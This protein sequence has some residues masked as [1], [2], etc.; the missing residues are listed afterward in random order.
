M[1][2]EELREKIAKVMFYQHVSEGFKWENENNWFKK[3]YLD[4]A[5]NLLK[6]VPELAVV[7]REAR[8]PIASINKSD[9]YKEGWEDCIQKIINQGWVKESK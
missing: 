3:L 9:E 4:R 7:D 8:L 6:E 2:K 5:D 1:T